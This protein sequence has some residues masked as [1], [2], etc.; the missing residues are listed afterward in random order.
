M[1]NPFRPGGIVEPEYFVGRKEEII[2]FQQ[3]LRN[4]Q[5]GNP[6]H[7]AILGERGIGKTSLLRYLGHISKSQ[8]CL[9]VR[10][11]FDPATNSIEELVLLILAE[12]KRAGIVYS[13]ID[14]SAERFKDFFQKY[15]IS[16]SLGVAKF[17]Q[18]EEKAIETK[19]EFRHR[20]QE[21][22][23]KIKG[24]I[25]AIIIMMDEAE[26]LEQINGSLQYL[27]NVF[28]RLSENNCGYILV[29]SGKIG[30][31]KQIKELHSPL[32]RFFTP[33]TLGPLK[34]EEV[35]EA[36]EKPFLTVKRNIN[37]KLI[38][39]IIDDSQGHPYIVQT[40]G[41]VLFEQNKR[42]LSLLDYEV[43]KPMIMKQLGDQ[44]FRDMLDK[45]SPEEQ[46]ILNVIAKSKKPLEM[47]T[48]SKM[49]G[50]ASNQIGTQIK[51]LL[52]Q[53]CIKKVG[54]GKYELFHKLFGEFIIDNLLFQ[55]ML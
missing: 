9:I 25:P 18:R 28:L 37:T 36:I 13:L 39:K 20:L 31:F 45:T 35:K 24:K 1:A 46:K 40:I 10:V 2:R 55:K 54:R 3:Y 52:Q 22:W 38:N 11:E 14:K 6:H 21:L 8:K 7:L 50:K 27:R 16:V 47:K 32:A 33:V 53:N 15:N 23:D 41:Y 12:I 51:R 4:T 30:L 34:P 42:E 44:L 19:I 29:L 48:I 49:V 43:L 5:E 26:Q 17:E